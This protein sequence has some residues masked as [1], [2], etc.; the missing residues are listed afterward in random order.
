MHI[1][2]SSKLT[3][4]P[5][6]VTLVKL[7]GFWGSRSFRV[8]NTCVL[9]VKYFI[10]I[11][12]LCKHQARDIGLTSYN[13][14]HVQIFYIE[15]QHYCLQSTCLVTMQLSDHQRSLINSEAGFRFHVGLHACLPLIS[16]QSTDFGMEKLGFRQRHGDI[17]SNKSNS[18]VLYI[19]KNVL[20]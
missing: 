6:G 8:L 1:H 13:S 18:F 17:V 4:D 12:S 9:A 2:V 20:S 15:T 7:W 11:G 5:W 19:P 3:V 16:L 10:K 14:R